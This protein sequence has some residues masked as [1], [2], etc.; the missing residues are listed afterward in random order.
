MAL[1]VPHISATPISVC[2]SLKP[3]DYSS[4]VDDSHCPEC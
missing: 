4:S 3:I 2:W 1:H